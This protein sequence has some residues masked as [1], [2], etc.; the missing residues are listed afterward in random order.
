MVSNLITHIPWAQHLLPSGFNAIKT[1]WHI[2]I[3]R[4]RKGEEGSKG[5]AAHPISTIGLLLAAPLLVQLSTAPLVLH[6]IVRT[7]QTSIILPWPLM[8]TLTTIKHMPDQL[9]GRIL[10]LVVSHRIRTCP[11]P[12]VCYSEESQR[13]VGQSLGLCFGV[14]ICTVYRIPRAPIVAPSP[15]LMRIFVNRDLKKLTAR[16]DLIE[17]H[18]LVSLEYFFSASS[19]TNLMLLVSDTPGVQGRLLKK[20]GYMDHTFCSER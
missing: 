11:F 2:M 1:L 4:G 3:R 17:G 12:E 18:L 10:Y 9:V 13:K 7:Q 19:H 14:V 15:H 6:I 20:G 16:A 5:A 8:I